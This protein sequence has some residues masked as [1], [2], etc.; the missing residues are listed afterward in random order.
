M[1]ILTAIKNHRLSAVGLGAVAL[2]TA[3]L[4][5]MSWV[6]SKERVEDYLRQA[7]RKE[8]AYSLV[9]FGAVKAQAF[10]WPRLEVDDLRLEK[11]SSSV[12]KLSV[13]KLRV[14]LNL[15]SWLWGQP[16]I[17]EM[18]VTNP[19]ILLSSSEKLYETEAI[20]TI[21]LN[22][23]RSNT[24]PDLRELRV[25]NAEV[26]VDGKPWIRQ[27][28]INVKNI[29][30]TDLRLRARA[31]YRD[32]PISLRS[33]IAQG[34][35]PEGREI[36]WTLS[37]PGLT[38]SFDGR[39]FGSKSIDAEGISKTVIS[40]GTAHARQFGLP[41][42]VARMLNNMTLLGETKITWPT[43]QMRNANIQFDQNKLDG[44]LDI[45]LDGDKPR[46]SATLGANEIDLSKHLNALT[47]AVPEA[48][49]AWSDEALSLDWLNNANA[50]I[51]LSV[52]RLKFGKTMLRNLALSSQIRDGRVEMLL[53]E[54]LFKSGN[55]RG[56]ATMRNADNEMSARGSFQFDKIDLEDAQSIIGI[57]RVKGVATGQFT[58][59]TRGATAAELIRRNEGKGQVQIRNGEFVGLDLE[60]L[61]TRLDRTT[62]PILTPSG[63][64]RFRSANMQFTLDAGEISLA[65]SS[66][67]TLGLSAPVEGKINLNQQNFDL[68]LRLQPVIAIPR[69]SGAVIKITGPWSKPVFTPEIS[70]P[71]DRS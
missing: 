2:L 42:D 48:A 68:R 32:I 71:A 40:D 27:L 15:A 43:I 70:R 59:D 63:S 16:R 11:E 26:M 53:S 58:F 5:S 7:L 10:P 47:D 20:S 35:N 34:T 49:E 29:A 60:R 52:D 50:D 9:S 69:L 51:R 23:L 17:V 38:T 25:T 30:A 36:D 56:R 65:E 55:M 6:I 64:T 37:L 66:F 12:E 62:Q 46:L 57:S 24:R 3:V 1:R 45:I 44:S 31:H 41:I 22:F 61:M 14:R 18:R 28:F 54:A 67:S 33:E 19:V 8:T 21:V 39:L 13:E 4:G